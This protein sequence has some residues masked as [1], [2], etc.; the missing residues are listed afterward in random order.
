V[1]ALRRLSDAGVQLFW[2]AGNRD[3]LVG[4]AFATAAGLT[5]PPETWVIDA[6]GERIVLVHGDAQCTQDVKC[7]AFHA[8]VRKHGNL[9]NA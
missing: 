5:L 9:L 8:Q 4:E 2:I 7:T 3:F 6:Y 1:S